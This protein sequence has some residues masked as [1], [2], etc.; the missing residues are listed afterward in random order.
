MSSARTPRALPIGAA[1][2][3]LVALLVRHQIGETIEGPTF[4]TAVAVAGGLALGASLVLALGA[5][6]SQT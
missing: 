3:V 4:S 2:L 5:R 6:R 1:I